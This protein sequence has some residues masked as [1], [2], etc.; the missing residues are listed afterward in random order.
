MVTE[1]PSIKFT[2]QGALWWCQ[3]FGVTGCG[4]TK[5]AA[6]ADMWML[7]KQAI[8]PPILVCPPKSRA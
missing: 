3:H 2:Q 4:P 7:Y 5:D 1:H 6:E 8:T